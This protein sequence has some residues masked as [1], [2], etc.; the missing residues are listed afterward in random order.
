LTT[1]LRRYF[2]DPSRVWAVLLILAF[3]PG[4]A[5]WMLAILI[6]P[7]AIGSH[8]NIY[9][10]AAAAWLAGT[11]PWA[12]GPPQAIFAGPPPMLIPFAPFVGLPVDFTRF[13]WFLA[14]LGLAIWVTRRLHLPAYWVSFPPLFDAIFLGHIE[15]LIL[16]LVVLKG[17]LSGLAITIKPYAAFALIAER[18]WAALALGAAFVVVTA[19]FL[20]WERFVTQFSGISATLSRQ[21]HGDSVFGDPL[22]MLIAVV[23]LGALGVRR[24]LWLGVPVLWPAAQ[25]IYKTM[26]LP[27]LTP[28]IALA[29]AL[30]VPGATLIGLI[31][32]VLLE[33]VDRVRPLWPWLRFGLQPA[34]KVPEVESVST[35][36]VTAGRLAVRP[37]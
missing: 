18:R 31:A 16:A 8:A 7:P 22:L 27:I 10:E 20:P 35:P 36:D 12:V 5:S 3:M 11:D 30:P 24:A 32:Q 15:V 26:T 28:V 33:R 14:D 37:L 17:P 13:A 6:Y 25:P 1:R 4:A 34:S 23:A 19:P 2:R 9:T 29:W 21:S